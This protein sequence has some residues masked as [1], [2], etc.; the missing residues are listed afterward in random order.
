M[1]EGRAK[2]EKENILN[3][4]ET[5]ERKAPISSRRRKRTHEEEECPRSISSRRRRS[6]YKEELWG[7]SSRGTGEGNTKLM[8]ETGANRHVCSYCPHEN[9]TETEYASHL[10]QSH[11]GTIAG[12]QQCLLCNQKV[13]RFNI[14]THQIQI[15]EDLTYH[16]MSE[17]SARGLRPEVVKKMNKRPEDTRVD[18][19]SA[20]PLIRNGNQRNI[21]ERI[22]GRSFGH[23][24]DL[25]DLL[26]DFVISMDNQTP[27]ERHNCILCG[28]RIDITQVTLILSCHHI[29]HAGCIDTMVTSTEEPSCPECTSRETERQHMEEAVGKGRVDNIDHWTEMTLEQAQQVDSKESQDKENKESKREKK[30]KEKSKECK[31]KENKERTSRKKVDRE[32]KIQ[33]ERKR[34]IETEKKKKVEDVKTRGRGDRSQRLKRGIIDI[35]PQS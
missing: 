6:Q 18:G 33:A 4:P 28:D 32:K 15:S 23:N 29:Y 13:K 2:R 3:N 30:S 26:W 9:T 34:E 31:A 8:E 14:W 7:D 25:S 21:Y 35:Y 27:R 12:L 1:K 10:V 20:E 22:S 24:A 16:L 17:H 19:I 5:V 11:A